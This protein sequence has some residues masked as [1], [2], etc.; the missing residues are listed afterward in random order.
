MIGMNAARDAQICDEFKYELKTKAELGRKYGISKERVRVII[1]R[2]SVKQINFVSIRKNGQIAFNRQNAET[3][4]LKE[5]DYAYLHWD[6]DRQRLIIEPSNDDS[7]NGVLI[8][9]MKKNTANWG[10]VLINGKQFFNLFHIE[11]P[12]GWR[13]PVERDGDNVII[14]LNEKT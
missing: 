1:R 10:G 6:G 9:H 3:L 8:M 2:E 12:V 11:I 4:G 5:Y 14:R 13:F 7:R